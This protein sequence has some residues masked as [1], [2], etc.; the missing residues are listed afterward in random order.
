MTR[1]ALRV[2]VTGPAAVYRRGPLSCSKIERPQR[3][4]NR[5]PRRRSSAVFLCQATAH[6]CPESPPPTRG[7]TP[8]KRPRQGYS[9][10]P[11]PETGTQGPYGRDGGVPRFDCLVLASAGR[12]LSK[13]GA[14]HARKCARQPLAASQVLCLPHLIGGNVCPYVRLKP[15]VSLCSAALPSVLVSRETHVSLMV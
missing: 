3:V 7:P 9:L 8:P 13:V 2:V 4:P 14:D 6:C 15:A 5:G 11:R 12:P 10:H 1:P